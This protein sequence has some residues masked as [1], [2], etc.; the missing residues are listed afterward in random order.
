MS[1]LK[2]CSE[3]EDPWKKSPCEGQLYRNKP[4]SVINCSLPHLG[5]GDC[6]RQFGGCEVEEMMV[7]SQLRW[8]RNT[9]ACQK[10]L[11]LIHIYNPQH[12]PRRSSSALQ[13]L[14]T[15]TEAQAFATFFFRPH[16]KRQAEVD[17]KA[18]NWVRIHKSDTSR[19]ARQLIRQGCES[20]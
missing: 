16:D 11:L 14:D 19:C 7:S 18:C 4:I 17:L 15:H 8:F 20:L 6:I 13:K 12:T 9:D 2:R 5:I 3:T 1:S 10:D